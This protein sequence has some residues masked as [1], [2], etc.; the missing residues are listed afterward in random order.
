MPGCRGRPSHQRS[1]PGRVP[2]RHL[3][4]DAHRGSQ[5]HHLM[6]GGLQPSPTTLGPR[7]HAAGRVRNEIHA[8]KTGHMRPETKP[9]TLLTPEEKR[10]SGHSQY[11]IGADDDPTFATIFPAKSNICSHSGGIKLRAGLCSLRMSSL[12]TTPQVELAALSAFAFAVKRLPSSRWLGGR[13][14]LFLAPSR[15]RS[16]RGADPER[17]KART[18]CA[19]P[20]PRQ[21]NELPAASP[22][23]SACRREW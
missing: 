14:I 12:A 18:P 11:T 8:G 7:Q 6:E 16:A 1:L 22:T 4:L 21:A 20:M 9:R 10:V 3:V 15:I 23:V 13:L 5:R 19:R 17:P 2:Q